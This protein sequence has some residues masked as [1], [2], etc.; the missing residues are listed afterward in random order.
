MS[1][2]TFRY[3]S[4][5]TTTPFTERLIPDAIPDIADACGDFDACDGSDTCGAYA[6]DVLRNAFT[7]V[8][9]WDIS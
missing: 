7:G 8:P 6:A 1:V 3:G 4:L 5:A 2:T 9:P